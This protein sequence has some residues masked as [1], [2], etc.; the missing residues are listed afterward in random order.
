MLAQFFSFFLAEESGTYHFVWAHTQ[1]L[2]AHP[3]SSR[4]ALD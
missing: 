3:A 2:I 1:I 4:I